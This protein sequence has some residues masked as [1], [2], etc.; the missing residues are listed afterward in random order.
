MSVEGGAALLC[1]EVDVTVR[2][3]LDGLDLSAAD[4]LALTPVFDPAETNF[5]LEAAGLFAFDEDDFFVA[6]LPLLVLPLAALFAIIFSESFFVDA[7]SA[8][9][10]AD[11]SSVG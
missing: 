7:W 1:F 5:G 8:K 2:E 4:F 10:D 6:F 11:R 3:L 9:P